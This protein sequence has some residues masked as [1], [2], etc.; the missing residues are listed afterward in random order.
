MAQ[1]FAVIEQGDGET[2]V[3][4]KELNKRPENKKQ[5]LWDDA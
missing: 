2:P 5:S 1:T 3:R 4:I